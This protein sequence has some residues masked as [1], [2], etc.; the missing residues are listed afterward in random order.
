M[1]NSRRSESTMPITAALLV[2]PVIIQPTLVI[3]SVAWARYQSVVR[4][5][6]LAA[7]NPPTVSRAI[8]DPAIGNPFAHLMLVAFVMLVYSVWRIGGAFYRPTLSSGM[9][10]LWFIVVSSELVAAAGMVVLSQYTGAVSD[11]LHA[12]GSYM[13]FFG[14]G[15]GISLSGIFVVIDRESLDASLAGTGD[16]PPLPYYPRLHPRLALGVAL[17]A[18][19]FCGLFYGSEQVKSWDNYSARVVFSMVELVLLVAFEG[20]VTSFTGL[21]FRYETHRLEIRRRAPAIAPSAL[22]SAE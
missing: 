2:A 12:L 17:C 21:M 20:Y 11:S 15:I 5:P 19:T 18:L 16:R 3:A 7:A 6:D 13:L 10:A 9:K 22:T 1:Q 8:V 14:H 4:H